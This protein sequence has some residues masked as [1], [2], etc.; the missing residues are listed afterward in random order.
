[1]RSGAMLEAM[2]V[3]S[4]PHT[5]LRHGPF[6]VA[7]AMQVG[8]RWDDLQTKFWTRM[9]RGQYVWV[10]LPQDARLKLRAVAQRMPAE[11]AF[12]GLTAA[13]LLGLDVGW[14]EPIEVTITRDLPV[15]AR[16][17]VRLRRAALPESDVIVRHRFRTTSAIRTAC[18][19]GSRSDL[20][21]SVSRPPTFEPRDLLSPMCV[22]RARCWPDIRL[23]RTMGDELRPKPRIVRTI[24]GCAGRLSR[25]ERATP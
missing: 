10:D 4:L 23:V 1:M 14:R 11:F 20:V 24:R 3:R 5:E 21:E 6:T 9:S 12:S 8:M 2:A 7:D 19:L 22:E 13:W 25:P 17:G 15:R 18:D 16:A